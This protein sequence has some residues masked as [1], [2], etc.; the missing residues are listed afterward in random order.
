MTTQ[1]RVSKRLERY[2]KTLTVTQGEGAGEQL[3]VLPWQRRFLR[4]FD[5]PGDLGLSIARGNG[6]T[7]LV[8][9]IA[10]A[11]VDPAGPLSQARGEVVIVA[12]S[13][14]QARIAYEHVLAFLQRKIDREPKAW[15]VLDTSQMAS[16]EHR[17]SG[18]RIRCIGSD[19]RRAH[20]LAPT[21]IL[22]DEPA[23][24]EATKQDAMVAAL[25][26]AMGKLRGARFVAL[27]TRPAESAHWFATFLDECGQVHA[28]P[29]E[30]SPFTLKSIR[31]ANPSV[32]HMSTLLAAIRS[33][34]ARAKRDPAA[35][36]Y[37]ESL[38]L[39]RGV[40]DTVEALLLDAA[41][42]AAM[43][44]DEVDRS[45]PYVL[46]VD[47]GGSAAQSAV[48][49][50]W[51]ETGSLD[52]IAAFPANPM[53]LA[54]RGVRDGQGNLYARC[55]QRGELM[56]LETVSATWA[57]FSRRLSTAGACLPSS[58]PTD[59]ESRSSGR[60]WSV[61]RSPWHRWSCGGR[62]GRMEQPT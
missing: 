23:Q 61:S 8:A 14:S 19:P 4:G 2:L 39:N 5:R 27:G 3:Q 35:L 60:S 25:R 36:A 52:A 56:L 54:E 49:A 40:P 44:H 45:G 37:Y 9:G 16:I 20:G 47:L 55:A 50:F 10:S 18:A 48:A 46:G 51:P 33:D 62:A 43:E 24:W 32:D 12:S 17:K 11:A 15:R 41:T 38:R 57:L 58:S 26:T 13:F 28:A 29:A 31:A 7:T 53:S 1:E 59:T 34:A 21:L 30:A 22:A 42:W 6:K